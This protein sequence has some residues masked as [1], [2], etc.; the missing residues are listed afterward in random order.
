MES[1]PEHT[2]PIQLLQVRG[3]SGYLTGWRQPAVTLDIRITREAS[4]EALR[5]LSRVIQSVA[6]EALSTT[7]SCR[8]SDSPTA[9]RIADELTKLLCQSGW[10]VFHR[11]QV[12]R[13]SSDQRILRLIVP[14]V[15]GGEQAVANVVSHLVNQLNATDST[16]DD[17]TLR[18]RLDELDYCAPGG[19]NTL[20]FLQAAERYHI[21]WQRLAGNLYQFG[22]GRSARWL[23]SSFTD[24]TPQI[25]SRIARDKRLASLLLRQAGLPVPQQHSARTGE[26]ALQAA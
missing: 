24:A 13:R 2:R 22:W 3:R 16:P 1:D 15:R 11:P 23:D 20:R 6:P 17:S 19:I 8:D 4:P 14:S 7:L 12:Y 5:Q 25:S 9:H 26:Q 21:P 10:P 18:R